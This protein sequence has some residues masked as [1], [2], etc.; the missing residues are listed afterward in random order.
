MREPLMPMRMVCLH[1][2]CDL[3]GTPLFKK[4]GDLPNVANHFTIWQIDMKE[5]MRCPK[6][7]PHEGLSCIE[8]WRVSQL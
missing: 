5:D 3:E 1:H 4:V 8:S 6:A 2:K 7:E